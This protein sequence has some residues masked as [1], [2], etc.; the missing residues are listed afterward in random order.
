VQVIGQIH[1]LANLPLEWKKNLVTI[2]Y[3]AGLSLGQLWM[4]WKTEKKNSL[5][6]DRN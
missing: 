3:G 1:A 6:P 2:E 4:F 5:A